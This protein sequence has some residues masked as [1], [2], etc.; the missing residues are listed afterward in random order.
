MAAGPAE[1]CTG[2]MALRRLI[3][4][5]MPSRFSRL[6]ALRNAQP[7]ADTRSGPRAIIDIG[8]NSV[9]LVVWEDGGRVPPV[10]FNEKLMA[11]L[12]RGLADGGSLDR[13]AMAAAERSLARFA[14]LTRSMGVGWIRT[15]ATAAVRR[16]KNGAAFVERVQRKT[17]LF[18]EVLS[19]EDEAI[20]SATGVAAA[21]PG[22]NGIVGD[23]GGGSLELVRI[24]NGV[25]GAGVSLPFGSLGIGAI[26]GEGPHAL[27]RVLAKTMKGAEWLEEGRGLPFYAVGG[28]WRALAQVHMDMTQHPLPM[29][30]QY[31]LPRTAMAP[32]V[33]SLA[34]A[35]PKRLKQVPNLSASRIQT[36]PGAAA[37]LS[38]TTRLIGSS[39]TVISAW[40]LREGL[41]HQQLDPATQ[42]LD[43][44]IEAVRH[45]GDREARF[46]GQGEDLHRWLAP[47]FHDDAPRMARLRHAACL[48][49]DVGWRA[50]PDFRPERG[51]E[52]ALHG[53]WVGIDGF[54]R[55]VLGAA[56]LANFGGPATHPALGVLTRL[57]DDASL[58]RARAWGLAMRLGL[59]M[60]GGLPHELLNIGLV[61]KSGGLVMRLPVGRQALYGDAI[62][63]R[64]RTLATAL[65]LEAVLELG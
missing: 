61:R 10:M 52:F 47:L 64:H 19:G 11:G 43:P 28:S 6:P 65:G 45:E 55:A 25:I 3:G 20:A 44:L 41:L 14:D 54:G 26:R 60:V 42:A 40:G 12:G 21:I 29:V 39:E 15:V 30:H 31:V 37:M 50:H 4:R 51:L 17:G 49:A 63:R 58:Q 2:A 8:S 7:E 27:D 22:A 18:I 33:R 36:L 57:A 9:R 5:N 62:A 59:R 23:L 32:L 1:D 16:A 48:L 13:D 46:A 34:Q 35:D 24:R 53:N 38:A 56:L